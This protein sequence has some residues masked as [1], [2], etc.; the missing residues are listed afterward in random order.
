M[1]AGDC[2]GLD[3]GAGRRAT[4]TAEAADW[5]DAPACGSEA[6][7]CELACDIDWGRLRGQQV[8]HGDECAR[9]ICNRQQWGQQRSELVLVLRHLS[10]A[11]GVNVCM[12][13]A[14]RRAA[15]DRISRLQNRRSRAATAPGSRENRQS[16]SHESPP[17]QCRP[18]RE[19]AAPA[20]FAIGPRRSLRAGVRPGRASRARADTTT[21]A[22]A[23]RANRDR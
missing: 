4:G 14:S 19:A 12:K 6:S 8:S 16:R 7:R 10:G 13:E 1:H 11:G 23:S 20:S 22:L 18:Y 15:D 5:V 17:A 9:L 21:P 3:S 2:P